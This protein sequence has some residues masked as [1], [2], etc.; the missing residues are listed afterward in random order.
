MYVVVATFVKP[1]GAWLGKQ[2]AS[3]WLWDTVWAASASRAWLP[4]LSL[5]IAFQLVQARDNDSAALPVIY[6]TC[7]LILIYAVLHYEHSE[8]LKIKVLSRLSHHPSHYA[9]KLL[10]YFHYWLICSFS[11]IHLVCKKIW[12]SNFKARNPSVCYSCILRTV[13][14]IYFTLGRFVAEDLRTCRVEFGAVWKHKYSL[15]GRQTLLCAAA[16]GISSALWLHGSPDL[17]GSRSKQLAAVK[18]EA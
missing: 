1:D 11:S 6:I 4:L 9:F 10:D 16:G 17:M 18:A 13:C 3:I 7:Y 5:L 2:N 8:A 12:K 14:L 15:S